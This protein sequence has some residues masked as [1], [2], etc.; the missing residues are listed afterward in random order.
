[1]RYWGID[2][3]FGKVLPNRGYPKEPNCEANR[4]MSQAYIVLAENITALISQGLLSELARAFI[5]SRLFRN[6][7]SC[8]YSIISIPLNKQKKYELQTRHQKPEA[9]KFIGCMYSS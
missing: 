8:C 5:P 9:N 2:R 6:Y 7:L 1:M 4:T 3:R